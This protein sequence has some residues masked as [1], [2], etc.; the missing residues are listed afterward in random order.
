MKKQKENINKCNL[1]FIKNMPK[2][3]KEKLIKL[4]RKK[5][6][7]KKEEKR[8]RKVDLL[9]KYNFKEILINI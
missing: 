8:E 5:V 7:R 1:I 3:L 9:N 4:R 6:V 2:I